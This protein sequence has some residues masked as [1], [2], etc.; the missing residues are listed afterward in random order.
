LEE[1]ADVKQEEPIADIYCPSTGTS[2]PRDE[3]F[4]TEMATSDEARVLYRCDECDKNYLTHNGLKYHS[5]SHT[6]EKPY[7]C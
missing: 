5:L 6:G 7:A 1:F 4:H 2:R 3:T